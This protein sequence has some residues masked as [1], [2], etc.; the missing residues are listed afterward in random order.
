MSEEEF[1]VRGAHEE[2]IDEAAELGAADPLSGA[3]H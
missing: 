3:S 2:A 1:E